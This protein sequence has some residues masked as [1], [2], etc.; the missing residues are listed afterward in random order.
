MGGSGSGG[1]SG[2]TRLST[3]TCLKRNGAEVAQLAT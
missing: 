3:Y 1:G 2:A